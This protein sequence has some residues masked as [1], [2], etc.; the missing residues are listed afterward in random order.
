MLTSLLIRV[1]REAPNGL[2]PR[3][4]AL[5]R[6]PRQHDPLEPGL[7]P[8]RDG[9]LR[10]SRATLPPHARDLRGE[11]HRGRDLRRLVRGRHLLHG[12]PDRHSLAAL[13]V[14]ALA[15]TACQP[16]RRDGLDAAARPTPLAK[17]D[18]VLDL[19]RRYV[20]VSNGTGAPLR[21][22]ADPSAPQIGSLPYAA[23]ALTTGETV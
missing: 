9:G 22:S 6:R 10:G 3:P 4:R 11:Q 19:G 12:Q 17:G 23:V 16:I 7:D 18:V 13:L 20:V 2:R 21:A 1:L 15:L 5:H 8:D 14:V